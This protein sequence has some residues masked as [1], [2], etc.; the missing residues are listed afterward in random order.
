MKNH[1]KSL[2]DFG[3]LAAVYEDWYST[4]EGK[5]HDL[6]QQKDV[7]ALLPPAREGQKLLDVGCGT[8]HWCR[9][10]SAQ[11][12]RVKGIDISTE[13]ISVARQA[14]PELSFEVGD[15]GT[16]PF[17][18]GSFDVTTSITALEF[19]PDPDAAV[20]EM[21][22]CSRSDGLMLI[23]TLNRIAPINQ[24]RLAAA[25]EPFVSGHLLGP[26]ELLDLISP[27]GEVRMVSSPVPGPRKEPRLI[28][29]NPDPTDMNDLLGPLLVALV[30]RRE[31]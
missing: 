23:G 27:F 19:F 22:R 12:Y 11:G 5:A 8:G 20:K 3:P 6:V 10:F 9:F 21:A 29:A 7:A 31:Q 24:E 18:D 28:L 17:D 16:L 2:F 13:M 4:P 25:V 14:L 30:R 15:A 26:K 1:L